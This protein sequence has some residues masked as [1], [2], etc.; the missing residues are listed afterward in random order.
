MWRY[1]STASFLEGLWPFRPRKFEAITALADRP[2][3][4]LKFHRDGDRSLQLLVLNEEFLVS[5][6]HQL[7]LTTCARSHSAEGTSAWASRIASP[8][9]TPPQW[10]CVSFGAETGLPCPWCGWPKKESPLTDAR[11]VVVVKAFVSS[12][13][14][15]REALSNDPNVSSCNDASTATPDAVASIVVGS[16]RRHGVPRHLRAPG[17]GLRAPHSARL[18]TRTKESDMCASQRVSKPARRKEADWRDP[19][20]GVHRRPTL[21][22]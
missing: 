1:P 12:R 14:D 4:S 11:L 22:F 19:P 7:A 16:A 9:T 6:S 18:E 10:G 3:K 8:P 15:A 20:R 21:I 2:G 5:A 17:T 13:A